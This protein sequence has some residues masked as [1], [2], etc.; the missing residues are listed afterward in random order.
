MT[1][2]AQE[3][4]Q[5]LTIIKDDEDVFIPL[6]KKFQEL[7]EVFETNFRDKKQTRNWYGKK[8]YSDTPAL[9]ITLEEHIKYSSGKH[10]LILIGGFSYVMGLNEKGELYFCVSSFKKDETTIY[11]N[12]DMHGFFFYNYSNKISCVQ[13]FVYIIN[14]YKHYL[15]TK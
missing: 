15:V 8:V 3:F 5:A 6:I 11:S 10:L 1:T 13:L 14:R 7:K 9:S 12:V 2:I 4:S